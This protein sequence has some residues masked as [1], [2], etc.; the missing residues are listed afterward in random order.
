MN[1]KIVQGLI[2]GVAGVF[3]AYSFMKLG[4]TIYRK[5]Y[6]DGENDY[7]K[8]VNSTLDYYINKK[9]KEESK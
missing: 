8:V 5:G 2:V 4:E 6:Y 9:G 1:M 3:S 7:A